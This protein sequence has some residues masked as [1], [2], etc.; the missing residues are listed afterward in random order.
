[1]KRGFVSPWCDPRQLISWVKDPAGREGVGGAGV[2]HAFTWVVRS[3]RSRK[4]KTTSHFQA[5]WH[6]NVTVH[7]QH[8]DVLYCCALT[9]SISV[10]EVWRWGWRGRRGRSDAVQRLPEV[11]VGGAWGGG[12]SWG[13]GGWGRGQIL[14]VL[15]TWFILFEAAPRINLRKTCGISHQW[16]K[17]LHLL[18]VVLV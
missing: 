13:G 9:Q 10:A 5:P 17:S 16:Y 8:I 18:H 1:M 4:H 11:G 2:G 7:L 3:W 12:Q 14:E 6:N 15:L